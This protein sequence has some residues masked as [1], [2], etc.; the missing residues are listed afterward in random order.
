MVAIEGREEILNCIKKELKHKWKILE[1]R[2]K[3]IRWKLLF[4]LLFILNHKYEPIETGEQ[5][6][7]D[8][9]W[10][11]PMLRTLDVL[12]SRKWNSIDLR[13]SQKEVTRYGRIVLLEFSEL[14]KLWDLYLECKAFKV[15]K[16][17]LEEGQGLADAKGKLDSAYE[18]WLKTNVSDADWMDYQLTPSSRT[19]QLLKAINQEL[20]D[21]YG[22][23]LEFLDKFG[24]SIEKEI[25]IRLEPEETKMVSLIGF[26]EAQLLARL[27]SLD[28]NVDVD[29]FLGELVYKPGGSWFRTPFI[30]LKDNS[31]KKALYFPLFSAFYP[32]NLFAGSWVYHIPQAA[33]RSSSLGIMG[34]EYGVRFEN[35]V[36]EKLHKI[37]PHLKIEPRNVTINWS[38]FADTTDCFGKHIIE[39][40]II[41]HSKKKVYLISCKALDQF[42]SQK[43]VRTL[44]GH[45][46][47]EFKR[48]LGRDIKTAREIE[49]YAH[50]VRHSTDYLKS[51]GFMKKEIVPILVTSDLRPLNLESV[52]EWS[53]EVRIVSA[54]PDVQII[55]ARK[56]DE[57][58][59]K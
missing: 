21:N 3:R 50:C 51:R 38:K 58:P 34:Q 47:D 1:L 12:L 55:Q 57:F 59:F 37:H 18:A 11:R 15:E 29:E 23:T 36:H 45:T 4:A 52:R 46:F 6:G 44:I 20:K 8:P 53:V 25:R 33:K 35:Y 40:D 16:L 39:I 13:M 28:K 19:K 17:V 5:I 43:M 31:I 22:V 42:Y 54:P 32:T 10:F 7:D 26:G 9:N 48:N 2:Y 49:D 24:R 14:G 56:M 27:R 41:A 30:R